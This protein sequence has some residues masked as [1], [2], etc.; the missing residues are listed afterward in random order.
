MDFSHVVVK[1]LRHSLA[2]ADELR[3]R[4]L[5]NKERVKKVAADLDVDAQQALGALRILRLGNFSPER[6]ALVA[7]NDYGLEDADI[8]EMW[9]RS[10]RWATVVRDNANEIRAEEPIPGELEYLDAG[11]CPGDPT[12]FE[13]Q[14]RAAELR[15]KAE[16]RCFRAEFR[17]GI[18]AYS[19]NG[20]NASFVSI[21]VA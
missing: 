3:R 6:L 11:L 12:P 15:A 7:M 19:W 2:L 8:A 18:R 9:G 4:C 14:Q 1:P 13:I 16:M 17:P 20:N 5:I 21:G 10:V